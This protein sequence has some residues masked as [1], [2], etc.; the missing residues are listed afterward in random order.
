VKIKKLEEVDISR[1]VEYSSTL[2]AFEEVYLA[3]ASPGKIEDIKV[4]IGSRVNKGDLLVEMDKTQQQQALVQLNNLETDYRR[5]DTLKKTGSIAE[6]KYDQIK[7][8]YKIAK[9][10]YEFL[11]DNTQLKAPFDGLI[12]G[13]YFEAGELYS[14]APNTMA[15]KAA[16]ITIVKINPLK[17]II[18]ISEN[19]FPIVKTGMKAEVI[20]DIYPHKIFNGNIY[21]IHPT[22]DPNTRSFQVEVKI[23]NPDEKLRPG[24][25]AR[26]ILNTGKEKAIMVP[27]YAVI[28]Q[29]GTNDRYVFINDNNVAKRQLIKIGRIIDDQIEIIEGLKAGDEMIISGQYRLNDESIIR[30]EN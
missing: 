6:Q 14:G 22:I 24:M 25:F 1:T 27:A 8:Q 7:A 13:K 5:L 9:S 2:V 26:T 4:E 10:N 11:S 15:G 12:S 16:I 30:I 18:S 23:S 17:S 28:K 20:C 29:T 21:R 19:Y 3:P